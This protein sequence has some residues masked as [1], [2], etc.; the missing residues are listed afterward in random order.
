ME[1]Y[2]GPDSRD[3]ALDT[4]P[5]STPE[6]KDRLFCAFSML[7][8]GVAVADL[9]RYVMLRRFGGVYLDIDAVFK[10]APNTKEPH[11]FDDILTE[12][13]EFLLVFEPGNHGGA[14]QNFLAAK[15]HHPFIHQAL[16]VAV[17]NIL[18]HHFYE[19]FAYRGWKPSLADH[20]RTEQDG[21]RVHK[22]LVTACHLEQHL[23]DQN[24]GGQ[25]LDFAIGELTGPSILQ[26]GIENAISAT[27]HCEEIE[28]IHFIWNLHDI[29]A[30]FKGFTNPRDEDH[31][32]REENRKQ[33]VIFD[34]Q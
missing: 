2:Y 3:D 20:W 24:V 23:N 29:T 16:L 18:N 25:S 22:Q 4:H 8:S 6:F 12:D 7:K 27:D 32:I 9:W 13:D 5:T 19:S 26:I 28:H 14:A 33:S 21:D 31:W 30:K 17:D 11:T 34:Q 10:N 1:K 15:A